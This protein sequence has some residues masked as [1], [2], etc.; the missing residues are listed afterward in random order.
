M[1]RNCVCMM[2]LILLVLGLT[3]KGFGFDGK[4]GGF[5]IGGGV[6]AG[7]TSY[8]GT[9]E[10]LGMQITSDRETKFSGVTN[11]LIGGGVSKNLLLYYTNKVSWFSTDEVITIFGLSGL[12]ITYYFDPKAPSPLLKGGLGFSS[13]MAPF[14]DYEDY[15]GFGFSL[16]AGYEFSPHWSVEA[17]II[18]GWPSYD[19]PFGASLTLNTFAVQIGI[20]G[21]AY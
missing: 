20:H 13:F 14:E 7:I 8:T 16:G 17:D 5:I 4:R 12:G 11:F 19:N 21:V 18:M 2:L 6:G 3:M 9:V 10:Y 1:C 15:W